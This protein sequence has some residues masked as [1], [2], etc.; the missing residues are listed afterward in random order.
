MIT[1]MDLHI[2]LKNICFRK[3]T[4]INKLNK[5]VSGSV[6]SINLDGKTVTRKLA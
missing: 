3:P 6:E 2:F 1:G 5:L 4:N